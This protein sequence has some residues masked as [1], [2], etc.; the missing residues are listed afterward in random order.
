MATEVLGRLP[1]RPANRGRERV[2]F[3]G[4]TV[5]MIATVQLG[6]R[7]T[8]FPVGPRP[9]ALSSWVIEVHGALFSLYLLLLLVQTGLIAARR[10]RW[11]MSLGLAVYGLAGLMIPLGVMAAADELR[12]DLAGG[13]PYPN[14]GIDP[15]TFSLVS[16][17]GMVMFGTLI[18]WS[19][20]ARRR[21]DVH[22]RLVLYATLSMMDAGVDRWPLPA[23]GM[24]Q[25]WATWIYTALL[26]LPLVYDLI[27]LGRV[28]WVTM[29]AAPFAFLLHRLEF[30][31]GQTHAWHAIANFML[32]FLR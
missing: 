7:K 23:M 28:H 30:P 29:F 20:L 13:A 16:V 6:F 5:L 26:L 31:L 17:M 27:S 4:M 25:G 3:C 18:T 21:P 22:K 12:R 2:F 11:H 19:Y 15:R 1:V 9:A 14:G 10:M 8:F 32:R 24:S